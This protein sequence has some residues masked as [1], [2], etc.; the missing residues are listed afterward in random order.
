MAKFL[1]LDFDSEQWT[2]VSGSANAG[3]VHIHR[4][5][6]WE[7]KQTL[8]LAT[9]KALGQSLRDHLK[10]ER[11]GSAPVLA[12]VPRDRLI[13]KEISYPPVPAAD[14]PAVVRFQVLR[15][16]TTAPEAA[17]IDYLPGPDPHVGGERRTLVVVIP[18]DL[19]AAYQEMF[20]AAG[21]KLAAL[22]PRPFATAI[23][24][25]QQ[26]SREDG[27]SASPAGAVAIMS[28]GDR[29]AE[30]CVVKDGHLVLARSMST[31]AA[32]EESAV[33]GEIRRN[34]AVYA[35][36]AVTSPVQALY[37][38]ESG[39][40]ATLADRLKTTLA[41]PVYRLDP[42]AGLADPELPT[43][44]RGAFAGAV[45]ALYA[46]TQFRKL[47][48]NFVHPKEA[49]P[50][51]DPNKWRALAAACAVLALAVGTTVYAMTTLAARDRELK[52]LNIVKV[53][54]E[55][56]LQ[57]MEKEDANRLAVQEWMDNRIIWLD[58]LYDLTERFPE[59]NVARL[60]KLSADP[61]T[62]TA[63]DKQHIGRI[64][65]EGVTTETPKEL[66]NL[67]IHFRADGYYGVE[68]LTLNRNM[69]R[70]EPWR[71]RSQFKTSMSV[72]SREPKKYQLRLSAEPPARKRDL[73][74]NGGQDPAF[75][76]FGGD[77]Q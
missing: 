9:A 2:V 7:E 21:V 60:T 48:I 75:G 25:T 40:H 38:A 10:A 51:R 41:I 28:L 76:G 3:R 32:G 77:Q 22:L 26:M 5:L 29:W 55:G 12:C 52:E 54:L 53:G 63:K 73:Q 65:L 27:G 24:L 36:Q 11:I 62:H 34:L 23:C 4:A 17:V 56:Q 37:V 57:Q 50:P 31:P 59:N 45:G 19:L 70:I 66:E 64:S 49:K 42:F 46:R 30:F 68:P 8:T 18:K 67:M 69:L 1:A 13:L 35:G 61:L 16:M 20:T 33:V 71:F 39:R 58:E 43:H 47:P 44:G 15:D 72:A 6:A 74:Q 14:E